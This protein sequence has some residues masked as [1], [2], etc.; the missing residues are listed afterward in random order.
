MLG[1]IIRSFS[2]YVTLAIIL[3]LLTGGFPAHGSTIATIALILAMTFSISNIPFKIERD[4]ARELL[5]AFLLNY[6]MLSSIILAMGA[7]VGKYWEGFVVMAFAP[8][9][10]AV[11]PLSA[12]LGGN[13]KQS[14]FSV[15]FLYIAALPILPLMVYAILGK[16]VNVEV[17][18]KNILLLIA[19]PLFLSRL[20]KGK[21]DAEKTKMVSNICFFFIVFAI[22]GENRQFLLEDISTI[23]IISIMM[24][25]R[26]IGTG[27]IFKKM[28]E[29][30]GLKREKSINYALFASFKNEGLVMILAASLFGYGEAIPAMIALI[31]ELIFIFLLESRLI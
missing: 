2:F 26:T 15:L 11:V 18:V 9:A 31:F 17:L 29:I 1:G 10:I 5:L 16:E 19:L 6:I 4:D 28:G 22:V 14:L 20:I 24:A 12:I 8:P 3:A 25:A 21:I 23:L 7:A 30:R 13:R 27:G